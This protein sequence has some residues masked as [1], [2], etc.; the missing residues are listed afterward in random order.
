MTRQ[1]RCPGN[2]MR[3][4]TADDVVCPSCHARVELF[5]D[6]RGRRCPKCGE[7]VDRDAVPSCAAWCAAAAECLGAE[8][9]KE[10]VE[11]MGAGE[12]D[13]SEAG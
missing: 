5:S 1:M 2:D 9:Y 13:G 8:R 10:F 7:R 6:E 4:I 12:E 11:M 3:N